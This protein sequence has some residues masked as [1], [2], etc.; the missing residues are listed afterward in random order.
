M[1]QINK[2]NGRLSAWGV[3]AS[4]V[5]IRWRKQPTNLPVFQ[6]PLDLRGLQ[7]YADF[8]D[9]TSEDIT[10]FCSFTPSQG[11]PVY[12]E[13]YVNVTAS[14]V[15]KSGKTITA[16]TSLPVCYPAELRLVVSGDV[17]YENYFDTTSPLFDPD[18]M[19]LKKGI[20][21]PYCVWKRIDPRTE[22]EVII[23][24]SPVPE[25]DMY[26]YYASKDGSSVFQFREFGSDKKYW[27]ISSV[28]KPLEDVEVWHNPFT[29]TIESFERPLVIRAD[30]STPGDILEATAYIETVPIKLT[31]ADLPTELERPVPPVTGPPYAHFSKDNIRFSWG[32][33]SDPVVPVAG[34]NDMWIYVGGS[35][36]S[37]WDEMNVA[38][39]D[40]GDEGGFY[41]LRR[42]P[43]HHW[44]GPSDEPCEYT[45]YIGKRVGDKLEWRKIEE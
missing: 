11:T 25:E 14:Y 27:A 10:E 17:L 42:N 43:A 2:D 45:G 37:G 6:H 15:E 29:P 35:T 16:D 8:S 32:D 39:E 20:V 9:G 19:P 36:T 22:Q 34:L 26:Y 23:R 7:I 31:Y 1:I 5:S 28:E 41:A 40:D 4:T 3:A 44:G 21:K 12:D 30:A 13:Q 38:F 33:Y 18:T 24:I